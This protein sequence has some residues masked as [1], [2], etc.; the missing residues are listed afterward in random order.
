VTVNAAPTP[1]LSLSKAAPTPAL[2]VGVNSS[3]VLTVT[4]GGTANATTATLAEYIPANVNYTGFSGAGW[5]CTPTGTPAVA[6]PTTVNCSFSGTITSGGGT[7]ALTI[8]ITPLA[9][10]AGTTVINRAAVDPT[11]GG[12][13]PTNATCTATPA[14][15]G[16]ASRS[17]PVPAVD[18]TS[19]FSGLPTAASPGST[20]TGV[21][22][23]TNTSST[24]TTAIG[25]TCTATGATVSNC[26]IN[27]TGAVVTSP[28]NVPAGSNVR[29]TVTATAPTTGTLALSGNT[30]ATNETN[31]TNNTSSASV[32]VIDAINDA[33]QTITSSGA[34][35]V[36]PGGSVLTSGGNDTIGGV[37]ATT[38][39]VT[40]TPTL[41]VTGG[42]TTTGWTI[43][44]TTGEISA[45]ANVVAGV[46]SVQYQICSNPA[47]TPVACDTATRQ[48]TVNAAPTPNL[49]LS[50]AAPTPALAVG[51]NS[52]YVLTVTN[53]GTANATTATLAEYIPANVNYT[54]FS[55]AGWTCTPTG[56]PAVAGPTTVNCS[57]SGTITSGGG[58]S[59]LTISITPLAASAGTTV[60][61]RAAVDP[62]GGGTPPTNA[63]C[64]ATPATPGCASR[65]DPVPAV[66]MTSAFS[67]LPTAA[68][69][70][71][72]V[73]GVLTCTNTSSTSTTAIGA[74]CTATGA[75]VSNCQ[76][77]GTGAVVTSP[78]N[79]P[80]G[81]NV[82][83]T[84]TATAPTTGTLALSGNTSAT[85]ETNTTNNTSSASVPV[86]DAINDAAA[87]ITSSA[88]VQV[89][90]GGSVL[91]SGGNDT[92]GG[93]AATTTNV[94]I[95]PTLTVTGGTTT[96]GWTINTT[97][98]AISAPAN[99]V[100]G[101]YSVQY[102]ICSNPAATP[103]A[104]D[105]ATRQVTVN[106]GTPPDLIPTFSFA[107]QAYTVGQLREVI[108]NIIEINGVT[109]SGPI[110]FFV[111][112]PNG[113]AFEQYV[114]NGAQTTAPLLIGNPAVDNVNWTAASTPT[115][116][117]FTL[118]NDPNTGQPLT[119]AA[120]GRRR[121]VLQTTGKDAGG[122]GA[123]TVNI[124]A[125]SGG[126]V[127]VTNNI[128]VL[129]TSV[130]R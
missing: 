24:S 117:L 38:T 17:D 27:G 35:Q 110:Q 92:L 57:F 114:F 13:P 3:Y 94:T 7:S 91:T 10:S 121:I 63:T 69:P 42:T 39:N 77:N 58:T 11:G 1:N 100:A 124:V 12:T 68:S 97:T 19:A 85:N 78:F 2:A 5:T 48:V 26:Q 123:I 30:S 29:C 55:G 122:K 67:G 47:A 113:I 103:V 64:T 83:C 4:N 76:I 104:C 101:V 8:S 44:T 80:A 15:P 74:T 59:A 72:T 115:G 79:V 119:I 36:V 9:A 125:T 75:T 66:D 6:G 111:P 70:G 21:L 93:V 105:T 84:V 99:V 40:I 56:T 50:K 51:V 62:T 71:S 118:N 81:S 28:F 120:N 86:I 22:T 33:A 53:G 61:N 41:T 65:S 37:A 102:Q 20:V 31:T 32:P 45:P 116:L 130:Q 18:M 107:S 129:L 82:R 34:V 87:T 108:I 43:N 126:E 109:T 128:A 14:T 16:C 49:S 46:Y 60:I 127:E 54:G 106:A 23:C 112:Q 25:A 52:S 96:T 89:V 90:P 95:T 73:T 88:S 98:G